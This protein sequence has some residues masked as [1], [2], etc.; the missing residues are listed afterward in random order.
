M[1]PV[2]ADNASDVLTVNGGTA[3]RGEVAVGGCKIGGR[4]I[5]FP[6]DALRQFGAVVEKRPE[7]LLISAP[8]RL[9]G[10]HIT[11]P[12]PS[13]GATEQVLLTAVLAEGVT[14]LSNAA[15]EPEIVD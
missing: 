6:P 5:D 14:E 9:R 12:F 3:L 8:E 1:D 13:V 11:L 7:G 10:T 4:P 2:R 15:T